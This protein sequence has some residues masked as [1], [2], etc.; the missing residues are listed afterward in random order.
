MTSESES[1]S[2]KLSGGMM[3]GTGRLLDDLGRRRMVF[4][5]P[6]LNRYAGMGGTGGGGSRKNGGGGERERVRERG[7]GGKAF[8]EIEMERLRRWY[9][10]PG[11]C[12]R[13]GVT[14]SVGGDVFSFLVPKSP[15][16][17]HRVELSFVARGSAS[18]EGIAL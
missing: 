11:I 1:E 16:S 13:G 10:L 7:T 12:S 5:P 18:M 17:G 14:G 9:P 4:L 6:A 2:Q 3:I 8:G 15:Q